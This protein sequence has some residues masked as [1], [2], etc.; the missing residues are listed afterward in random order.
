MKDENINIPSSKLDFKNLRHTSWAHENISTL[1]QQF[2]NLQ[3]LA[4]AFEDRIG[5]ES[6]KP[7]PK[8]K[9][10]FYVYWEYLICPQSNAIGSFLQTCIN[11][12]EQRL[13]FSHFEGSIIP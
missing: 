11:F 1:Q 9:N 10:M 12:V 4:G 13:K 5:K 7:S 6:Q 3:Q 8:L 2:R